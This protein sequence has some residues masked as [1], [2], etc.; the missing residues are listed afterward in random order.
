MSIQIQATYL[1]KEKRTLST[2][3]A[4]FCSKQRVENKNVSVM[5]SAIHSHSAERAN[6]SFYPFQ[7]S[8]QLHISEADVEDRKLFLTCELSDEFS[9]CLTDICSRQTKSSQ[10]TL[11]CTKQ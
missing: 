11:N 4:H 5:D 8:Q 10:M 7:S 2:D 9:L 3:F 1:K 6:L